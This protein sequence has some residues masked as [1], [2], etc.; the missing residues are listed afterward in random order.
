MKPAAFEYHRPTTLPEA[1]VLLSQFKS[2]AQVLAGG[3]SLIPIMALRMSRPKHV[4]DINQIQE[5]SRLERSGEWLRVGALVR[6]E[7]L[8]RSSMVNE[9]CPLLGRCAGYI[10]DRQIRARGTI[11]GSLALSYPGAELPT[12]VLAVGARIVAASL[13][14]ERH[15]TADEFFLDFMTTALL[16]GEVL[17]EIQVPVF[18]ADVRW[19]FEEDEFKPSGFAIASCALTVR[20]GTSGR[21]RLPRVVVS[22]AG[23]V[24]LRIADVEAALEGQPLSGSL[25]EHAAKVAF[26]AVKAGGDVH[27]SEEYRRA[28]ASNCVRRALLTVQAE[29][30]AAHG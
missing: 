1:L 20:V 3:Q 30:Y 13:D 4:V 14:N 18:S 7:I 16:E 29:H 23:V 22:G 2:E 27:A 26:R 25:I 28:M 5:L 17:T 19:A 8:E 10:G 12:A 11:G 9:A 15:I 24:P 6:H 21:C